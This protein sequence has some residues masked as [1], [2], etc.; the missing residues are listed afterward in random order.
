MGSQLSKYF[1][2]VSP[3]G[4]PADITF[5]NWKPSF[6]VFLTKLTDLTRDSLEYQ[7]PLRG[8]FEVPKVNFL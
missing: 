7:W 1:E 2:G 4:C 8:T 6:C 5:K 3:T